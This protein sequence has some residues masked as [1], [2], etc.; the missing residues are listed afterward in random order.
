VLE[1]LLQIASNGIEQ[2]YFIGRSPVSTVSSS[3]FIMVEQGTKGRFLGALLDLAQ[4]MLFGYA[5]CAMLGDIQHQKP[6]PPVA[7]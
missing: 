7:Y 6:S 1:Q 5:G 3:Q 4:V 2:H